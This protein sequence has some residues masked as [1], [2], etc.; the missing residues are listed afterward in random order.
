MKRT[1]ALLV[2]LAACGTDGSPG[3]DFHGTWMYNT[4]SSTTVSCPGQAANTAPDTGSFTVTEGTMSD[5]IVVP[6]A[7]DKC[8]PQKFDVSGKTATVVAGQ[9]CMYTENDPQLGSVMTNIAYATGSFTLG[10]DKKSV[11]GQGAGTVTFTAASGT[12]T[13]PFTTVLTASKVGN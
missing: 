11:S 6:P 7:G 3:D 12:V 1:L 9:T 8:P 2:F 13:C 10:G 4:G 5:I